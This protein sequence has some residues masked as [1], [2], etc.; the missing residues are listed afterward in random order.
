MNRSEFYRRA[1]QEYADK[2]EDSSELT[3][4]ANAALERAGRPRDEAFLREAA[5][6]MHEST[7]W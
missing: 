3:A 6:I 1:A 7:E 5:R 2:L 4:I